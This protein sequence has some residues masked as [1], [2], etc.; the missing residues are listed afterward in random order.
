MELSRPGEPAYAGVAGTFS[1]LPLVLD[2][3]DLAG[4]DVAIVGAPIDET[5]SALY[6]IH[7]F[8]FPQPLRL[9]RS[10]CDAHRIAL[11]EDCA[12]SLFS[13]D[14]GVWLGSVG[15]L[16]LKVVPACADSARLTASASAANAG[17]NPASDIA[18]RPRCASPG[19]RRRC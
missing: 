2:P 3:A 6:V 12:L 13:R 16:A 10:F 19:L 5:V 14:D 9:A 8:G 4:A 17:V 15:D 18:S 11:I 1:K 7:Y